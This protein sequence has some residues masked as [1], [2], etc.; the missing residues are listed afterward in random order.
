MDSK[1]TKTK[2]AEY[3]VAET[4]TIPDSSTEEKRLCQKC[5]QREG[6]EN[7][8]GEGGTLAYVHGMYQRWC[9]ICCIEE[10]LKYARERVE[11]IPKLIKE[12]SDLIEK[13]SKENK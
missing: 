8:T 6:T 10:Q 12:L 11:S 9:K 3:V 1:V 5:G 2:L 4:I 7:W 13:E